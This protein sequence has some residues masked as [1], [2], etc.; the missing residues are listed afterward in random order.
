MDGNNIRQLPKIF[1]DSNYAATKLCGIRHS[2][3]PRRHS[4]RRM[5]DRALAPVFT[6]IFAPL[7]AFQHSCAE[8]W[9]IARWIAEKK[10]T[11]NEML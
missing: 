6:A 3:L 9:R 11:G 8:A 4:C 1:C 10:Q 7:G 2:C 5:A